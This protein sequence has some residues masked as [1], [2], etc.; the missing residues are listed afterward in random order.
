MAQSVN[1]VYEFYNSH[2][3]LPESLPRKEVLKGLWNQI[4]VAHQWSNLYN[5]YSIK[6]KLRS[7]GITQTDRIELNMQQIELLSQV[8]HNRWNMEKLLLGFRKPTP[9]EQEIID[10][11]P[12]KK[13]EYKNKWFA[14]ADI[15]PYHELNEGSKNYDKCITGGIP[16]IVGNNH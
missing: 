2:N 8:E 12:G 7:L 10:R 6:L 13:K 14:H 11:E 4:P 3:A 5:A 16:V 15:C 9:K 1:Y